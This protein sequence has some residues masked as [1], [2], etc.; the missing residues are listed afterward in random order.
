MD[1]AHDIAHYF[2]R[3][4]RTSGGGVRYIVQETRD[5]AVITG[6]AKDQPFTAIIMIG[7]PCELPE[8]DHADL[9]KKLE[10]SYLYLPPL[11]W[12]H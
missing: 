10:Q 7:G 1:Q 4:L 11:E 8:S 6:W 3:G 12:T 5:T 9:L 2:N